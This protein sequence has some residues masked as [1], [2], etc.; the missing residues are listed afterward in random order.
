MRLRN[1]ILMSAAVMLAAAGPAAA[2]ERARPAA[3]FTAGVLLFPDDGTVTEGM[4]GGSAR[5]YVSPRVAVGPE[6]VFVSGSNH[7]HLMATGNLT[8]DLFSP[9][10]SV[11]PFLVVG[12]GL[13]HSREQTGRGRFNSTEGA[14]TAG[15]GVRVMATDSVYVAAEAR[16]GWELHLRFNGAIGVRF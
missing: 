16:I 14:F 6:L 12:G 4:F 15:G 3:E 13:F 7:S 10:R 1:V 9:T 11:T 2:Q 5:F 8:F